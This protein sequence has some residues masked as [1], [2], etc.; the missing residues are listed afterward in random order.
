MNMSVDNGVLDLLANA[1]KRTSFVREKYYFRG[2][3]CQKSKAMKIAENLGIETGIN[4]G[5]PFVTSRDDFNTVTQ[6]IIDN[7]IEGWWHY[8]SNEEYK[9]LKE[10]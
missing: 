7:R 10:K 9:R 4:G 3:L 2:D 8:V 1:N 6:Y 5:L